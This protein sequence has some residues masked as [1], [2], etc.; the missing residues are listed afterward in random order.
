MSEMQ[1]YYGDKMFLRILDE[2]EFWK[3]QESEHTVVIRN[4]VPGLEEEYVKQLQN[5]ELAL[6]QTQATAE[7]YMEAVIRSGSCISPQL[8]QQILGF[9]NFCICQSQEFIQFLNL[10]SSRS[11]A[12]R[13][14]PVALVVIDHIRRES[15][16]FI[17]I[18]MAVLQME[19]GEIEC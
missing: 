15:E 11:A 10:I 2:A 19:H 4:I 12:I 18:A 16:Y 17:G 14:N 6:S 9:I 13:N 8:H 5:W 7:R 3:R 1:N